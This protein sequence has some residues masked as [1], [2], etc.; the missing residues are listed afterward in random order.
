MKIRKN[1]KC[2]IIL[3]CISVIIIAGSA[4]IL[5][6]V[7]KYNNRSYIQAKKI[8]EAICGTEGLPVLFTDENVEI[9]ENGNIWIFFDNGI[10]YEYE[11][12]MEDTL[13]MLNYIVENYIGCT[14][15]SR[16]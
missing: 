10:S 15:L 14:Y 16:Y 5:I 6:M 4:V 9:K 12:D 1:K 7:A 3:L 8:I 2:K 13:E 11:A